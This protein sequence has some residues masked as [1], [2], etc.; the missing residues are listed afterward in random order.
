MSKKWRSGYWKNWCRDLVLEADVMDE[1]ED[2][3]A[4]SFLECDKRE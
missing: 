1:R 2:F 3:D 4:V